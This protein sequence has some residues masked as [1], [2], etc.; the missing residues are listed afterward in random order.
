MTGPATVPARISLS[1]DQL[2]ALLAHHADVLAS[3]LQ[4]DATTGLPERAAGLGRAAELLGLHAEHLTAEKEC[5]PVAELL[6]SMLSFRAP[7][8][9][10]VLPAPVDQTA[11]ITRLRIELGKTLAKA[12]ADRCADYAAGL[13]D[14]ADIAEQ[15]RQ[16]E[17]AFGARKSAQVSENV[18]ILRVAEEL[19]RRADEVQP[20]E[21]PAVDL[22]TLAAA[23]DGFATLL[24]TSSR[25]WGVYRVDAWLY[26]VICGWDCEQTEHDK[27][28]VHG[29]LEEMQEQHG[30]DDDTVAKARRYR[31][32][33]RT[34]IEA[35]QDGA[36]Q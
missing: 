14:A 35:H 7:S 22:P 10:A 29:A 34:L 6:D 32:A 33:V 5:P 9:P 17:P 30:W 3:N 20:T 24:A 4:T 2:A 27:T 1:R 26:A 16:F 15:Q 18:G 8:G 21:R 28:C 31:A 11:E 12:A 23:L 25:D 36:Q 19:R 13:R